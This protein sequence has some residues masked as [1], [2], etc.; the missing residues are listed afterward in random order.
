MTENVE[1]EE[2]QHPKK[3]GKV[4][5]ALPKMLQNG[6]VILFGFRQPP[7]PFPG[8][9]ATDLAAPTQPTGEN[10]ANDMTVDTGT[11]EN[12]IRIIESTDRKAIAILQTG[13]PLPPEDGDEAT[14][15]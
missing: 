10:A 8:V 13:R 6:P 15:K 5:H 12:S 4:T 2:S 14:K 11:T 3:K 9:V 7:G 1:S